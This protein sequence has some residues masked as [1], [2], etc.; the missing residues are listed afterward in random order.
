LNWVL[1]IAGLIPLWAALFIIFTNMRA[2]KDDDPFSVPSVVQLEKPVELR[3]VEESLDESKESKS[4]FKG[5]FER[6]R[7]K[8]SEESSLE[9]E[10]NFTESLGDEGVSLGIPKSLKRFWG[11][12]FVLIVIACLAYG[13]ERGLNYVF[14]E[15]RWVIGTTNPWTSQLKLASVS[16]STIATIATMISTLRT[17][18]YL[19]KK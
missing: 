1:V 8:D 12:T 10:I 15:Y 19:L 14:K 6:F 7:K 3:L 5:L 18:L 13:S 9:A 2:L 16:A 11:A 4:I 17:G